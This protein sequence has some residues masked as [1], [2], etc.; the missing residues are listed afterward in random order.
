MKYPFYLCPINGSFI[1]KVLIMKDAIIAATKKAFA[2]IKLN[3]PVKT[4]TAILLEELTA[5]G[6]T[7]VSIV[8]EKPAAGRCWAVL[9]MKD[10]YRVNVRCGYGRHNYAPCVHILKTA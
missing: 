3:T 8:G 7:E 9:E 5:Q 10:V 2:R 4:R 1:Q 6:I